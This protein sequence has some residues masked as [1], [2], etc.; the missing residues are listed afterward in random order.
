MDFRWKLEPVP[1]TP[2]SSTLSE[3]VSTVLASMPRRAAAGS[4]QAHHE[5]RSGEAG[6]GGASRRSHL[7]LRLLFSMLC[8]TDVIIII[9][10]FIIAIIVITA[11]FSFTWD[12]RR[13]WLQRGW[14][15]QRCDC[16]LCV[17]V[18]T[19]VLFAMRF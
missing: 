8:I 5:D 18:A 4:R 17:C 13:G 16:K 3:G 11:A 7:H 6:S 9:I 19:T 15:Q 1:R 14:F 2:H 12:L 10:M